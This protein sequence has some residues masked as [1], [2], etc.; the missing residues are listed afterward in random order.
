MQRRRSSPVP[1]LLAVALG[2]FLASRL[3][4]CGGSSSTSGGDH[5]GG[6]TGDGSL[7]LGDGGFQGD[8]DLTPDV[9]GGGPG[10]GVCLQL[11]AGCHQN[12]D[13]CSS[14]CE[15]G[16]CA[17]PV[18]HSDNTACTSNG[19]C[20][21][22]TCSSGK[23]KPLNTTCSTLGN[24]C[25]SN[26]A[27]CSALCTS[28]TC[29]PSSFCAQPG[30]ACAANADC[31]TGV[32]NVATG[33]TLG[34][35]NATPPSG[36]ANCGLVDGELCG[37]GAADG[38]AVFIDSGLPKCGG[39]CCSRACAP[40]GPTGVLV[41]QPA[42]GCH[43]VGDLCTTDTDCCG[44]MGIAGGSNKPVVCNK[45]G[46]EPVGIC[47]LPMGCKPN[48]DVCKLATMS[49]NSSCDCCAGNCENDDTCKQDNV[50]VPRCAD[51]QCV[52]AGSSCASSADCCNGAPCV[53]NASG[54][55]PYVCSPNLCVSAC[56]ACTNNADCCPGTS[57]EV[58]QGS[59]G[60]ICGPCGGGGNDGGTGG[61]DGGVTIP[62]DAGCSLFGQVCVTDNNCCYGLPCI[63]GRCEAPIQ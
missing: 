4:G 46:G 22:Q 12:G 24:A 30:D 32:C 36:P 13:C 27:C 49:C 16:A 52:G 25:T 21:S 60:G 54:T 43:P 42:S 37:G 55:P 59:T 19:Q 23:C 15:N 53:P 47:Q 26:A 40:W 41:C 7:L 33:Q 58:P 62:P 1:K 31:C 56:G 39:P 29:Q 14:D 2:L 57:C 20:C 61:G 11:G 51:A 45:S 50:G 17:Y 38:G 48:G 8:A 28:G 34:T 9:F 3:I 35:C 18:C 5:D 10:T 6:I 44:A 63:N